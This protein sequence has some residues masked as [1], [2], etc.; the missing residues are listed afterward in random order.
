MYHD[1]DM[2]HT[3]THNSEA[4]KNTYICILLLYIIYVYMYVFISSSSYTYIYISFAD[5]SVTQLTCLIAADMSAVGHCRD[6]N[7]VA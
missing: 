3:N 1:K 2:R 7:C 5:T 4:T 6:V